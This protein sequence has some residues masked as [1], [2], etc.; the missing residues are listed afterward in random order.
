MKNYR[1]LTKAELQLMNLLWDRGEA[2]VNDLLADM[3]DPKP[4]YNTV[5]TVMRVLVTKGFVAYHEL[6]KSHQYYPLVSR[7]E[8]LDSFIS[9]VKKSFFRDSF[10]S[11]VSFFVKKEKLTSSEIADLIKILNENKKDS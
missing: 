4:A 1:E 3:P 5:S 2:F 11:L 8:Y 7:E 6:G 9:S 10:V